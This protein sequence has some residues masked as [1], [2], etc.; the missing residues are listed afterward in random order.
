MSRPNTS[1]TSLAIAT[2]VFVTTVLLGA[3][4]AVNY[5]GERQRQLTALRADTVVTANQ[6]GAALA[7]PLWNFD[8]D[9]VNK[10]VE[11]AMQN[12]QLSGIMVRQ[13]DVASAHG[14]TVYGRVRNT[15]GTIS[16]T[17][18]ILAPAD[19]IAIQH[20]IIADGERVGSVTVYASPQLVNEGLRRMLA[21]L[22]VTILGLDI[23]LVLSLYWL[24]SVFALRP[25]KAVERYAAAVSSGAPAHSDAD[26]PFVGEI[27]SLRSSIHKMVDLLDARYTERLR[28]EADLQQYKD[29]L[30][31]LVEQRTAELV[32]ARNEAEA[33]NLA[34]S[35]FLANMSHELRTPLNAV[36]G[37]SSVMRSD[38]NLSQSQLKT[39]DIINRSGEHLLSLINDVL[40]VARI[41]AGHTSLEPTAFDLGATIRDITDMMR[42][43]AE[44]KDLDL[45]FD[46]SSTF[47]RFVRADSAKLRQILINLVNNAVKY[48]ERGSV[49]VRLRSE[50]PSLFGGQASPPVSSPSPFQGEGRGE[51]SNARDRVIL[52]FE[53]EDTGPGI[54]PGDIDRIFEPFVQVGPATWRKGTGLGLT[55]T[56]QYVGLMG[57]EVGVESEVGKGS[58]FRVTLPVD[59]A[60]ANDLE[61][62]EIDR[63]TVI[64][65]APGQPEYRVLVVE[66]QL[67][68]ALLM[69][70]LL[71]AV[72]F[73]VRIAENGAVGV[74]LFQS[75]RP[76][77]VWMDRRMPVMD[78]LEAARAIRKLPG[79]AKVKIAALT[80]SAFSTQRQET[81][82]AGMDD[83]VRKP[84]RP[85]EIFDCMARLLGV[86][87]VYAAPVDAGSQPGVLTSKTLAGLSDTLR[88]NLMTALIAL[89][90]DQISHAI[91]QISEHDQ[92]GGDVLREYADRLAY[93]PILKALQAIE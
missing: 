34:K 7:L 67:E 50:A 19:A 79:G 22:A 41:E 69:E 11:S 3:A 8:R 87:Y 51:V 12:R 76:Q 43:K 71:A 83:F 45:I 68:N 55:I 72:G 54:E 30:E 40:D 15:H 27:E 58:L 86:Q 70:M 4:G 61:T 28:T 24:L 21:S 32:E 52:T 1:I 57:G 66:D 88:H 65:I 82:D 23:I 80:A 89:D 33:A 77:F 62:A 26:G 18:A 31:E 13:Q 90:Q 93:T 84:F 39:L 81:L 92:A 25:L 37:F 75:W 63:G 64:G 35:G 17:D 10:V 53:V 85:E 74:D 38:A 46:Q 59:L 91:D 47:P 73:Q 2:L 5:L 60:D 29:H 6:L 44:E 42:L 20:D 9:Q 36:L 78:G 56:R 14:A 16:T 48:T 49:V